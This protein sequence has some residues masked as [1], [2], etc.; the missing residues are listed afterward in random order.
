[1]YSSYIVARQWRSK[2]VPIATNTQATIEKLL[3]L[4][5]FYMVHGAYKTKTGNWFFPEL[6]VQNTVC[7]IW[8][9]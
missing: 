8:L 6:P 5:V 3:G 1:V 7:G 9:L 4:I 2:H